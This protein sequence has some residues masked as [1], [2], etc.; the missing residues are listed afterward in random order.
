M[1]AAPSAALSHATLPRRR[2]LFSGGAAFL[3]R[4]VGPSDF[5]VSSER[6]GRAVGQ[7]AR[8]SFHLPMH[9]PHE[10]A[11]GTAIAASYSL[12]A[13]LGETSSSRTMTSFVSISK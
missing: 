2:T 5:S 4:R 8:A 3:F 9:G 7:A 12:V 10:P 11:A 1:T 13:L 6:I